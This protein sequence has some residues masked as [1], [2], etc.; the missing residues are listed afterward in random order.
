[1]VRSLPAKCCA[2]PPIAARRPWHPDL[3]LGGWPA[4]HPLAPAAMASAGREACLRRAGRE[5]VPESPRCFGTPWRRSR[6]ICLAARLHALDR[7]SR[8]PAPLRWPAR[9]GS[10]PAS[11]L[12][13]PIHAT[14]AC[15]R[16]ARLCSLALVPSRR[17]RFA[18]LRRRPRLLLSGAQSRVGRPCQ[19]RPVGRRGRAGAP[20]QYLCR[21]R[22][23]GALRRAGP[24]YPLLG[25]RPLRRR[26]GL[27]WRAHWSMARRQP[28]M[29]GRRRACLR[30]G[31]RWNSPLPLV[32]APASGP[33]PCRPACRRRR[34]RRRQG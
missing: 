8:A 28:R 20:K 6:S 29:R 15:R 12:R 31:R 10:L 14:A 16:P 9:C 7:R 13:N 2:R 32:G 23:C 24:Q 11:A 3:H 25:R 18:R 21:L 30:A 27:R 5:S 22:S 17:R 4:A 1:M 19:P 26:Q 34:C 33:V